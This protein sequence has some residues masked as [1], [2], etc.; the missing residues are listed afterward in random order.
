MNV[1]AHCCMSTCTYSCSHMHMI[2]YMLCSLVVVR[3]TASTPTHTTRISLRGSWK[4]DAHSCARLACHTVRPRVEESSGWCSPYFD[5]CAGTPRLVPGANHRFVFSADRFARLSTVKFDFP[6][7]N[8]WPSFDDI[9]TS[10]K[11]LGQ[12]DDHMHT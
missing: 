4:H 6:L 8:Y 10:G 1:Y 2:M 3:P 12:R 9:K 11:I 7:N 5:M